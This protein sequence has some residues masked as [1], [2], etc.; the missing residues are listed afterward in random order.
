MQ[1]VCVC[2]SFM[3]LF[4]CRCFLSTLPL[5]GLFDCAVICVQPLFTLT[6]GVAG[7]GEWRNRSVWRRVEWLLDFGADNPGKVNNRHG[8]INTASRAWRFHTSPAAPGHLN[9]AH[10]V[11]LCPCMYKCSIVWAACI[12][13]FRPLSQ[14]A[15]LGALG[16]ISLLLCEAEWGLPPEI[17]DSI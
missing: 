7:R 16:A 13:I 6:Y 3:C 8:S 10:Q 9:T 11:H 1:Y 15:N 2:V 12:L 4:R 14:I 17:V 5:F